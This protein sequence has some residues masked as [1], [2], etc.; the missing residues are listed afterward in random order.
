[1]AFE[2]IIVHAGIIRVDAV[3]RQHDGISVALPFREV[4]CRASHWIISSN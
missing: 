3:N 4:C 1:M 2:P